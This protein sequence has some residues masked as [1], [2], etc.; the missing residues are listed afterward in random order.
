HR[1]RSRR[2]NTRGRG[3]CD[4]GRRN[5][6]ARAWRPRP[7]VGLGRDGRS[8]GRRP[9]PRPISTMLVEPFR[10]TPPGLDDPADAEMADLADD[11]G[12]R[13]VVG[14]ATDQQGAGLGVDVLGDDP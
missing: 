12:P 6:P 4:T 14:R 8:G 9:S 5:G 13:P 2:T 11:H 10:Y 1:A 3:T 7:G